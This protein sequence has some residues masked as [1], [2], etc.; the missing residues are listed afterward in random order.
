MGTPSP[1]WEVCLNLDDGTGD[2]QPWDNAGNDP[3]ARDFG[4]EW[5]D[6]DDERINDYLRGSGNNLI[7]GGDSDDINDI[8][9]YWRTNPNPQHSDHNPTG[10]ESGVA[11]E[12]DCDP[13]LAGCDTTGTTISGE[14]RSFLRDV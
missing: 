11:L 10:G 14:R 13:A 2:D 5:Y 6:F 8:A 4:G 12:D 9:Y 3:N 1:D 7:T